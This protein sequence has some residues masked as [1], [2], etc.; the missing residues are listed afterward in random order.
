MV[1]KNKIRRVGLLAPSKSTLEGSAY[2][3]FIDM[4]AGFY[5]VPMEESSQDYTVFSTPFGSFKW[6]RMPMGLTGSP[7]T[8]QFLVEKVLFG[9][10][11]KICVPYLDHIIIFSST[12]EH[13][14]RLRLVFKRFRSHNIKINPDKCQN[15]TPVLWSYCK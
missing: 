14:E 12:L 4:S 5:Q 3:T 7:P 8:F 10:T 2:F 6:L 11:W 9:L 13:L 1:L 15:E